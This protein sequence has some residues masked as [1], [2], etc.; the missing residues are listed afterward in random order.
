MRKSNKVISAMLSVLMVSGMFTDMPLAVN[1]AGTA[2]TNETTTSAA[3]QSADDTQSDSEEKEYNG[4]TYYTHFNEE[5]NRTEAVI[6]GYKGIDNDL[7]IPDSI[8]NAVV[9]SIG[10]KAFAESNQFESITIPDSIGSIGEGAFDCREDLSKVYINSLENWCKIDFKDSGSQPMCNFADL[11]INGNLLTDLTVPD[12][13]TSINNY[14][15]SGCTSITSVTLPNCITK[16]CDDA[17]SFCDN[18][19]KVEFGHELKSIGNYAFAYTSL[20]N[21]TIPD[22]VTYIGDYAFSC[23]SFESIVI[24]D[25]LTSVNDYAFSYCNKLKTVIIPDSVTKIGYSAFDECLLISNVLFKG[26]KSQWN[27]IDFSDS[28]YYLVESVIHYDV[29]FVEKKAPTC[30]NKGYDLYSCSECSDGVKINYTDPLGH[31]VVSGICERCGKSEEDFVESAHPYNDDADESWTIYKKDADRIVI[32]FSNTTETMANRD[33]IYLYDK[34]GEE[35]GKYSGTEL[36]DKKITVLGDT[37]KIRLVSDEGYTLFGFSLSNIVPYYDECLHSSTRLENEK[38]PT[39]GEEGYTGDLICNNCEAVLKKGDIIPATGKH[40]MEMTVYPPTCGERGYT[41][42]ICKNCGYSY[43]DDYIEPTGNH[44]Y[45]DG[46]CKICG[47]I[48]LENLPSISGNETQNVIIEDTNVSKCFKFTPSQ[49]GSLT[50]YSTGSSDTLGR[51]LDS[52]MTEL[53]Y[54]D[55]NGEDRNF[56]ISYNVNAGETYVLQI[57]AFDSSDEAFNVTFN[58]EPNKE[59]LLGDVNGDGEITIVDSTILQK[60]IV[61]QTTLDDETL[62][63]ADVNKDGAITVVDA[64]LIQKFVVKGITEF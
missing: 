21:I 14:T 1:A 16:I 11:Y 29:K 4:F 8:D 35:I 24:P 2:D 37:V 50:F 23:C 44:E 52:N 5:N 38:S 25:S 12:S 42:Y 48:S 53:A 57:G 13:I 7:V 36:A 49:S 46:V 6:T 41:D 17:F 26:S 10:E 55:D 9:T 18:L 63:V 31:N 47:A 20:K 45:I 34:N 60:Y 54:N 40:D 22:S 27:S 64:T 15:F 56:R 39:C 59:T 30:V 33:Y 3:V 28:N 51:L 32:T 62:N 43:T 58:F 61:G 19:E